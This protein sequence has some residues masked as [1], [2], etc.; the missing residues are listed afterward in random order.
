VGCQHVIHNVENKEKIGNEELYVAKPFTSAHG[1]TDG[2]EGPAC[3]KQGTL[4]VVNYSKQ[5][6]IGSVSADGRCAVYLELPV[7][8]IGNGIRFRRDG[9]MLIADYVGHNIYQVDPLTK[10]LTVFAHDPTMAQPNDICIT[11]S[12]IVFAS[13][14]KWAD[15]SGKLWRADLKGKLVC[16]EQKMSTTNGIDV[17]PD[18]KML[19]VNVS[20][21]PRIWVYDLNAK[22]KLSHKRLFIEFKD[23]SLDGMRTDM[24]GNL[25]VARAGK[26]TVAK[27]SP[28]G[29]VLL[30]VK[31]HGPRPTN[32]CFGGPDGRTVYVTEAEN[33]RIESFRVE[34]PGRE[35]KLW[36]K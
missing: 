29:K 6:T 23:F 13:D 26:G 19:Y 7:P 36:Q 8:S 9:T 11:S 20:N 25:Y 30:E 35:W 2:I 3:D 1:F 4:Y 18:E 27:V 32:V 10:K 17:S 16:L 15:A 28:S 34:K 5:G 22:G 31:L 12:G 33:G 14:P 24:D 21:D